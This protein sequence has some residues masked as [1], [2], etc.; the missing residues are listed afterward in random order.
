MLIISFTLIKMNM[1]IRKA[2][3][4]YSNYSISIRVDYNIKTHEREQ[5]IKF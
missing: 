5:I 2:K 3:S 4:R 1:L